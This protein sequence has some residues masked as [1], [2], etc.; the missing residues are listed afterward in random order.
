V[1]R[2][3]ELTGKL[4]AF[5]RRQVL[6]PSRVDAAALLESLAGMLR[7]TLDQR[8][9]IAVEVAPDAPPVVADAG[10]LEAALLNVAINARDAMPAGGTI[11]FRCAPAR[12]PQDVAAEVARDAGPEAGERRYVEIAVADDG[13]G[14]PDEVRARAFEPF[15]T[16]KDPGRGTGLGL[17]TVYGFV[18]QSK[19]AV[20]LVSTAGAGTV[21]KLYLPAAEGEERAADAA[22]ATVATLPPGLRVLLVEDEPEVRRVVRRLLQG[23]GATVT[24]FSNAEEAAASLEAVADYDLLL[25]DIA[26]GPGRRGTELAAEVLARVPGAAALLMSGYASD[27]L[28]TGPAMATP[29]EVLRKPFEREALARAVARA[30]TARPR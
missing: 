19:G 3:A 9:A 15:F 1:R 14:M 12:L 17:S 28:E 8:I 25:T 29:W 6:A 7:R 10:Q 4:L 5:S 16:T 23:L 30:L 27:L 20:R 13:L 2:G 26:L 18:K 11:A 24:E 22:S 21:L